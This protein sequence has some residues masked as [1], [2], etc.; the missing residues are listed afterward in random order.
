M[1]YFNFVL[2]HFIEELCMYDVRSIRN[3]KDLIKFSHQTRK[4][5][6][7]GYHVILLVC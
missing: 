5:E 7:L 1:N 6:L 4:D 2:Q 3:Y